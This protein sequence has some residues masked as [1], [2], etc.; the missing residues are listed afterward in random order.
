MKKH[1][2]PIVERE[3][4][5]WL[6]FLWCILPRAVRTEQLFDPTN[7]FSTRLLKVVHF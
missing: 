6:H 1:I 3:M 4:V 2:E 5:D 7:G